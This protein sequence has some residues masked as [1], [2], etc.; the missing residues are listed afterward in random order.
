MRDVEK[1]IAEIKEKY[2]VKRTEWEKEKKLFATLRDISEKIDALKVEQEQFQRAAEYA[3]VA[4]IRYQ[5]IPQLEKEA[6]K[7]QAELTAIPHRLIREEVTEEDIAAVVARWTGVPVS[8][9]LESEIGKLTHLE[10]ELK[11]SV[12][13]Q[14]EAVGSVAR[15]IRRSRAGLKALNRPIGSFMFL[16]PTGVG[17]TELARA[18]AQELFNDT[19]AMVRIDMSEYM[20]KHAVSRLVGAP[21]GY[22][23]YEEGGQLTE[24]VRR[25]PY[26]VILFDE[27]EKAH[28][29]VF[30]VLLQVLD[31]GRLTDGQ[32]KTVN[33]SNTIIIMTS[34]IGSQYI[35]EEEKDAEKKVLEA[36]RSH[37]RPE[38][39]N[40]LDDIIVFHRISE[41][42]LAH[43]V[44]IQVDEVVSL[45]K[46]EK[47]I[48]LTIDD[49][50]RKVLAE[51]GYDP[52]YGARP[53]KRTIQT[54]LLDTLATYIIDG[55][56]GDGSKVAVSAKK[57][58]LVF[59][60]K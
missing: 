43:I 56:V 48:T 21:P 50:A 35:V 24:P 58:E 42:V 22:V 41:K 14:D 49:A 8:K 2:D 44:E 52:V 54:D 40:R 18:L 51:R 39:L 13:G 34:N 3:R 11:K 59:S 4:E 20:E 15:A 45:L 37:F 5:K 31:D 19:H 7:A 28:P 6:A 16:G 10:E 23:G 46:K 53:L 57:G 1:R 29:E 38:F 25:R 36:V 33:F 17:K 47:N 26:S 9:L 12:V 60:V 55:T 30:N 32:G 27:V